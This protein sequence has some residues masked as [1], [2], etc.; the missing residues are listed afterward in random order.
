MFTMFIKSKYNVQ[1]LK[2]NKNLFSNYE[3]VSIS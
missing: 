2:K 1:L 3:Q